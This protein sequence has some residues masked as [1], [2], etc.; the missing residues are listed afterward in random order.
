MTKHLSLDQKQNIIY[1]FYLFIHLFI[2]F[3]FLF[4]PIPSDPND[5]LSKVVPHQRGRHGATATTAVQNAG[6]QL[7]RQLG[8]SPPSHILIFASLLPLQLSL[9]FLALRVSFLFA[10]HLRSALGLWIVEYGN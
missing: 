7:I 9:A 1:L 6:A 10:A 8:I 3:I 2:Y 5:N 4:F